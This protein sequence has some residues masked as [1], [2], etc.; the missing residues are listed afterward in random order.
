MEKIQNNLIS[1]LNS[2]EINALLKLYYNENSMNLGI[3]K[4]DFDD[5][6]LKGLLD[7]NL[8]N[9]RL[10]DGEN[11]LSLS[12]QGLNLCGSVMYNR[13]NDK[14]TDLK[15]K[16]DSFPSRAVACLIN[17]VMWRDTV[18]KES[19]YIDEITKPYAIDESMWYERVL[20]K[21]ERIVSLLENFYGVLEDFDLIQKIDDMAWC[22]PEVEEFL[23][24]SYN[25]IMD[26]SW[27]EED[28]L[29]YY[30]FFYVYAQDQKNLID[31]TGDGQQFRSM[32]Y[33]DEPIPQDYWFSSNRSDPRTL[34]STLGLSEN[35]VI[36]FLEKMQQKDMVN[37]RYYPLSNSSFF[38][39]EDKIFVIKD[40][41]S[42]MDFI[43]GKFL[44]SVV[45][46]LFND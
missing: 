33:A 15:D 2:D 31:F 5:E 9:S 10:D 18:K 30:Y 43:T 34:L 13:I 23:K 17:R 41:K 25:G 37:E 12:E 14:K 38:S 8:I 46:S 26:L 39:E 42:Y 40:I 29:K 4:T 1:N 44:N 22:A 6:T 35:R 7:K 24:E 45:D 20:L 27:V 3:D 36:A 28:S 21:D 16:L 11:I 32:F 19:G